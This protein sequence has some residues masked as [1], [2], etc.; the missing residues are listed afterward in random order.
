METDVSEAADGS[1]PVAE[2][3][4]DEDVNLARAAAYALLFHN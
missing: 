1:P 2:T 4:G 3:R